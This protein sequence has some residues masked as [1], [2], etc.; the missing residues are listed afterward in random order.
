[1]ASDENIFSNLN[2]KTL[3]SV[4]AT[5][6][7]TTTRDVHIERKN[8]DALKTTVLVNDASMRASGTIIPG[9]GAVKLSELVTDNT[10]TTWF[11]PNP[12]EVWVVD[13]AGLRW[14][15]KTGDSALTMYYYDGTTA[16]DVAYLNNT[17]TGSSVVARLS[18]DGSWE[19]PFHLDENCYIQFVIG[20]ESNY[21]TAQFQGACWR[22]R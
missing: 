11:Q 9:T 2:P 8:L 12:G 20:S 16:L 17:A 21:S 18:D 22:I 6:I 15:E 5:D 10:R 19:W 14:T 1:M 4:T 3:S 7:N 13:A